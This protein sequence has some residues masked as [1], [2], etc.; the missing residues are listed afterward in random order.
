MKENNLNK[1]N[2]DYLANMGELEDHKIKKIL[3]DFYKEEQQLSYQRRI[4]HG[5]IDILRAELTERLKKNRESGKSIING[6]DINKLSEIL[7]K[8]KIDRVGKA[9]PINYAK[10]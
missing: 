6:E 8:G 3:D 7:A 9:G 2:T 1:K 5:K 10:E 4:I